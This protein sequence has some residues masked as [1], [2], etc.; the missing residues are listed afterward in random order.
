MAAEGIDGPTPDSYLSS[1]NDA[2]LE[3][4][5]RK[6]ALLGKVASYLI[7][8]EK[9]EQLVGGVIRRLTRW[10]M[11]QVLMEQDDKD[12]DLKGEDRETKSRE[13]IGQIENNDTLVVGRI[14]E[15]VN[16]VRG[17]RSLS[18][19]GVIVLLDALR[20]GNDISI[21]ELEPQHMIDGTGD[22]HGSSMK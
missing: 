18:R 20:V 22:K 2:S 4:V 21:S 19:D 14:I 16:K 9:T 7:G 10:R 11:K 8:L 17:Y 3:R 6:L 1:G 13:I 5:G 15:A 12:G